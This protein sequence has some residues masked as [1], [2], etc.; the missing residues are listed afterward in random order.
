MSLKVRCVRFAGIY[1]QNMAE[2]EYDIHKYV[3]IIVL[4]ENNHKSLCFCHLRMRPLYLQRAEV[5][6]HR[7]YH[8]ALSCFYSSL[9][10]TNKTLA[11]DTAFHVSHKFCSHC[12]FS[13]SSDAQLALPGGLFLQK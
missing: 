2:I 12:R 11:L 1:R 6:F 7:V 8:V 10:R 3:F 9:E 13:Y 5:L 4:S